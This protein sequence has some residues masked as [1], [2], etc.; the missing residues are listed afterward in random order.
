MSRKSSAILNLEIIHRDI[1]IND[2]HDTYNIKID[3]IR[4]L[5]LVI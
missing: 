1:I 5:K 4:E 3:D 2:V